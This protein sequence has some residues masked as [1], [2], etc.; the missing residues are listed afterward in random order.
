MVASIEKRSFDV[1]DWEAGDKASSTG[2]FQTLLGWFDELFWNGSANGRIDELEALSW[3]WFE[4]DGDVAVLTMATTLFDVFATGFGF[5]ADGFAV[6]DLWTTDVDGN[7]E[8]TSHTVDKDIELELTDT[9]DDGLTG[10]G[11]GVDT[12][13][14]VLFSKFLKSD[15]HLLLVGFGFW[16]DGLFDNR[17]WEGE[18]FEDD[19]LVD[20]AEG[21]T[22]GSRI[23]SDDGTEFASVENVDFLTVVGVHKD[24]TADTLLNATGAVIDIGTGFELALVDTD[25]GETANEWVGRDLEG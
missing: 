18:G 14:W 23:E 12:E 10:F 4:S 2:I 17:L 15:G 11:V 9:A 7:I 13:G 3:V 6:V 1:N 20:I 24:Q 22:G 16:L 5:F 8:F 19:F 25:E 21:V